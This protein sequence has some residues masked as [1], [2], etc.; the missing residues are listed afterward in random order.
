MA[1]CSGIG[2]GDS[3]AEREILEITWHRNRPDQFQLIYEDAPLERCLG[4][5]QEAQELADNLGFD[6]VTNLDH[7]ARWVPDPDSWIGEEGTDTDGR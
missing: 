7:M 4:T 1:A 5:R 2:N 6:L 3:V